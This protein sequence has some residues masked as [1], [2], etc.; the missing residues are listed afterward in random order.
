MAVSWL[1]AA[2]SPTMNLTPKESTGRLNLLLG[3]KTVNRAP[4]CTS[5]SSGSGNAPGTL[6][7]GESGGDGAR[8]NEESVDDHEGETGDARKRTFRRL[9]LR[10]PASLPC[11]PG[12][13][14]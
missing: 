11:D 12:R 4:G 7:A 1:V 2:S 8:V 5:S 6:K 3:T 14:K 13:W 10:T 9:G